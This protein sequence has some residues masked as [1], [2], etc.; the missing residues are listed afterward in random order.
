MNNITNI[1]TTLPG[2]N[3]DNIYFSPWIFI[4]YFIS[5]I[6]LGLALHFKK[7]F[8]YYNTIIFIIFSIVLSILYKPQYCKTEYFIPH[9]TYYTNIIVR[10][11]TTLYLISTARGGYIEQSY[12][13]CLTKYKDYMGK[14]GIDSLIIIPQQYSNNHIYRNGSSIIIGNDE[15][16]II[17]NNNFDYIKQRPKYALVCN[18]FKGNILDISTILN[19]DT[20]ILSSDL[21][22]KRHLRYIDTCVIH[23]IPYISLREKG[24][25]K[26]IK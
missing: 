16:T 24:F 7:R 9:D 6:C 11:S 25:H 18:G 20:I 15:F 13:N 2:A 1:I 26:V 3:I 4:P 14:R 10:D 17:D 21:H 23:N 5:I 12:N 8:W 22:K 19:P